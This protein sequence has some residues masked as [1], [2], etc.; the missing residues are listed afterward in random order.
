VV[1]LQPGDFDNDRGMWALKVG[2]TYRLMGNDGQAR[3]YGEISAAAYA[4]FVKRRPDDPQQQELLGRALALA[5]KREEAVQAGERSLALRST[6]LDA[7]NG[8]YY[9]Y[10]VAR[11]YM[12]AGQHDRAL[13]LIEPLISQPGDLTPGWL[14]IDPIFAPLRGNPRFEKLIK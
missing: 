11:I 5:G 10:Q 3:S 1:E 9:K 4:D 7:V 6:A 13:D 14:R 12:Q 2:N 8:P